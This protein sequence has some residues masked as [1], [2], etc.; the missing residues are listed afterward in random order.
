M[1]KF[2]MQAEAFCFGANDPEKEKLDINQ[3]IHII[4]VVVVVVVDVDA[5]SVW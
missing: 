5:E 4:V 1:C 2:F 3:I